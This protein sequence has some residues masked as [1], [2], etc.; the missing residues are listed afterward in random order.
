MILTVF[1]TFSNRRDSKK[2]KALIVMLASLFLL[3]MK[4]YFPFTLERYA[5]I[6]KENYGDSNDR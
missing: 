6:N 4:I 3:V 1:W 5:L 2:I